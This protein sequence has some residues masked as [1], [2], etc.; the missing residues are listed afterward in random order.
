MTQH[1]TRSGLL[2]LL[3]AGLLA[4]GCAAPQEDILVRVPDVPQVSVKVAPD[5]PDAEMEAAARQICLWD[6]DATPRLELWATDRQADTFHGVFA[7]EARM[8]GCTIRLFIDVWQRDTLMPFEGAPSGRLTVAGL[9]TDPIRFR[10]FGEAPE[11]A[12]TVEIQI[13]GQ[14]VETSAEHGYY[15][16]SAPTGGVPSSIAALD[17]AGTVI[18]VIAGP[19]LTDLFP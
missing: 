13:G 17:A 1:R 9:G 18:D 14:T 11:A 4:A 8:V 5:A 16:L 6:Q 19:E 3:G 2:A 15:A 10:L 7:N 12:A